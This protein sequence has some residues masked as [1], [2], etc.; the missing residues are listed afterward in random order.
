[1]LTVAV[2]AEARV[3]S[4]E[5]PLKKSKFDPEIPEMRPPVMVMAM[6]EKVWFEAVFTFIVPP[7]IAMAVMRSVP[8]P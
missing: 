6:F 2:F 5:E 8:V 3:A 4:E 1:M 7:L